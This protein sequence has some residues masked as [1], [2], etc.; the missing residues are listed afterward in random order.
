MKNLLLVTRLLSRQ[1][2]RKLDVITE[3]HLDAKSSKFRD[4]YDALLRGEI[5]NDR[6]AAKYLYDASPTDA[7]YRQLKSRFRRR[8]LNT[9]FFVDQNRPSRGT[10]DQ[11]FHN[12][13][14]DWALANI[15]RANR[16]HG[17]ASELAKSV[18]RT[19]EKYGFAELGL[20]SARYLADMCALEDDARAAAKYQ[21]VLSRHEAKLSRE[22]TSG[23]LLRELTLLEHR[24]LAHP[25][26]RETIAQEADALGERLRTRV[27][28]GDDEV[29][30]RYDEYESE[31]ILA[32]LRH[33]HRAVVQLVEDAAAF[34]EDSQRKM[35][36]TRVWRLRIRQ[37]G[38]LTE[39]G[40]AGTSE[41]VVRK[42]DETVRPGTPEWGELRRVQVACLLAAERAFD[43]QRIAGAVEQARGFAKASAPEQEMWQHFGAAAHLMAVGVQRGDFDVDAYVRKEPTFGGDLQRLNAWR[44]V[45]QIALRRQG[46]RYARLGEAI[47]QLRQLAVKQLN[48]RRDA[49]LV[50]FAQLL[51]RLERNGFDGSLDRV[52]ER[53][54]SELR[55]LPF[56]CS[57]DAV[58]FAPVDLMTL[59]PHFGLES[60][61]STAAGRGAEAGSPVS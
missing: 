50:S 1:K 45:L 61:H 9:V 32:H 47:G 49:R 35:W 43:A 2:I 3:E 33:D 57:V 17:P 36:P 7:R 12:C 56:R 16:L 34:A 39:L 8:L 21:E 27:V 60:H 28:A 38:A 37:L 53:H 25:G 54:L 48:G 29:V 24:A 20:Q 5:R 22:M 23:A 4:L 30:C 19:C 42:L 26:D 55:A 58:S 40:D 6:D 11:T 18:L 44:F 15:L 13:Q 46:N 41:A 14:R 10:F 51:Y 31:A 52:A 59:L